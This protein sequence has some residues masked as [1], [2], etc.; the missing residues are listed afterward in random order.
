MLHTRTPRNPRRPIE[1]DTLAA[2]LTNEAYGRMPETHEWEDFFHADDL[3]G[4]L[5]APKGESL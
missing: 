2:A 3:R 1:R 5:R 4:V